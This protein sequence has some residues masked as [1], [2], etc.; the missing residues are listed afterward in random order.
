MWFVTARPAPHRHPGRCVAAPSE[1]VVVFDRAFGNRLVA[2]EQFVVSW[3]DL[4]PRELR[5]VDLSYAV[6][7]RQLVAIA[8]VEGGDE[9]AVAARFE[10][11][12]A[13]AGGRCARPEERAEL[14]RA[15]GHAELQRSDVPAE[16]LHDALQS[17]LFIA[18]APADRQASRGGPVRLSIDLGSAS[19]QAVTLDGP[20]TIFLPSPL[21]PP[22]GD[23]VL[24]R[25]LVPGEKAPFE[26]PARV[27]SV[28]PPSAATPGRPAG[29]ALTL[30]ETSLDAREAVARHFA[31]KSQ[32][33]EPR[34]AAPRYPV[35]APVKLTP[36]VEAASSE[37]EAPETLRLAYAEDAELASDFLE[38]LSHGGAF[39]RTD[40]A[41]P[42]GS[43]VQLE[44]ALPDG[45]TLAAPGTVVHA[46]PGG[47]G[48][49]FRLDAAS[50]AKLAAIVA[51]LA[52]RQ[53]RVL[54]AGTDP[55]LA[56]ALARGG[57][58][59]LRARDG[60][61]ALDVLFDELFSIDAI[62]VV[63]FAAEASMTE[64]ALVEKIRCTGGETD[65]AIVVIGDGGRESQMRLYDLGAD[66]VLGRATG[67]DAIAAEVRAAIGRRQ[68]APAAPEPKRASQ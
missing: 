18:G 27:A 63:Q 11:W 9:K 29:F 65:L 68:P 53:T 48:V 61:E 34:R 38:N 54:I 47:I 59:V 64:V 30:A 31:A 16:R 13:H 14:R 39:V 26:F 41:L 42:H 44:L 21:A 2:A 28:R 25:I 33:D 46:R 51:R 55:D 52:T 62:V 6:G 66:A 36:L 22:V 17:L 60:R 15:M 19:G 23:R 8:R 43:P 7:G 35:R 20:G 50:E 3:L 56:D 5:S 24:A 49:Q 4:F 40:K 45:S 67:A 37:A 1:H 32:A 10:F 12:A 57:V 58:E